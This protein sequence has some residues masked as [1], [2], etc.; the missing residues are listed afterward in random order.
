MKKKIIEFGRNLN[1]SQYILLTVNA[2]LIF[3][4]IL[5]SCAA[6][7]EREPLYSQ[8]AAFRWD[9]SAEDYAQVSMFASPERNL[10]KED[11]E[12]IRNSIMAALAKESFEKREKGARLWIDA[13][14][15]ECEV[16][17][18]K[19]WNTLTATAVGVGNDFFLFHP[20]EFLSGNGISSED[21]NPNRMIL[22]EN[23]AWALFG[24][25]DIVGMQVWMGDEVFTVAGVVAVEEDELSRLAYGN[26]NRIYMLYDKLH[27]R[28][29]NAKIT[30]YEAVLP[31]PITNYAYYTVR[32]ACGLEDESEESM[33][34]DQ[35]ENVLNFDS[36][37]VVENSNRFEGIPLFSKRKNM[38]LEA[39]RTNSISY[40]YW[41]NVARIVEGRQYRLLVARC[42]LL[43]VPILSLI[44][45]VCYYW[46]HRSW[47]LRGIVLGKIEQMVEAKKE[48][49]DRQME[50]QKEAAD[51]EPEEHILEDAASEENAM[52]DAEP[53]EED[54]ESGETAES[55][56]GFQDQEDM[57]SE[58]SVQHREDPEWQEEDFLDV[59]EINPEDK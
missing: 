26:Q 14:S 20:M 50:E 47:S 36:C 6:K 35:Q 5:V 31:N 12:G 54:L 41:E 28:K 49:R 25:N 44:V 19:D 48:E 29:E 3:A 58:E 38:K 52:E 32:S 16:E 37:E 27:Q 55:V 2:V 57:D 30:C 34:I 39:M 43:I 40:P 45:L 23:I 18:R 53:E 22:D 13:Y 11:I 1:R 56:E 7:K 33:Q 21:E 9:R 42:L 10:Q 59:I 24:S 17:V 8:Q 4:F 46:S 51:M 15:G